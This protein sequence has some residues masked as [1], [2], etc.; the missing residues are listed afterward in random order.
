MS[1]SNANSYFDDQEP[2]AIN[3]I[4]KIGFIICERTQSGD[5]F[6]KLCKRNGFNIDNWNEQKW[7]SSTPMEMKEIVDFV[8]EM[9]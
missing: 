9:S 5:I 3:F 6:I 2:C 4:Q 1:L 8:Y 7:N